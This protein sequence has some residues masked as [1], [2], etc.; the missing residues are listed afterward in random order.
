MG[1]GQAQQF[2]IYIG[3][4]G[5]LPENELGM[6]GPVPQ[7][8]DG[9]PVPGLQDL[10]GIVFLFDTGQKN[11]SKMIIYDFAKNVKAG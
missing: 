7:Q 2:L 11:A 6:G 3:A 10:Y 8:S 5:K 9:A 1:A 4:A